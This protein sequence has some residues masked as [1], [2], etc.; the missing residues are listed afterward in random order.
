[1]EFGCN[2]GGDLELEKHQSLFLVTRTDGVYNS[3]TAFLF[4][5][6]ELISQ[7]KSKTVTFL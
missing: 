4:S 1:V 2:V 6:E 5:V 7:G 3:K